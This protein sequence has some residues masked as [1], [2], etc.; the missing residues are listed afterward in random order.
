MNYAELI[1]IVQETCESTFTPEQLASFTKVA[2]EKLYD[3]VQPPALRRNVTG[4]VTTNNPYLQVPADFRYTYSMA[5]VTDD[6]GYKF[7]IN[8]DVNFI[9]EAY[10]YPVSVGVP[11]HYAYFDDIVFIVGPTPDQDYM[12]ELHYGYF[13]ESIST[14]GT[15]WMGDKC[16]H[17]LLNGVLVEAIRFMKGAPD[18]IALYEKHYAQSLMLLKTLGDGKLREDTY[19]SGQ[20]RVPVT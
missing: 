9:R 1:A 12:V 8:K 10:P 15:T 4:S 20:A 3:A 11:R 14:A 19:R 2:E 18:M 6:C 5:V 17:A 7:L 13:P 16:E